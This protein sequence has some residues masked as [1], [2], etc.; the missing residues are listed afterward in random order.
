MLIAACALIAVGT[1]NA[2]ADTCCFPDGTC[3]DNAVQGPCIAAG[4]VFFSGI[5]CALHPCPP[6]GACCEADG[7]CAISA[8][9]GC[10]NRGGVWQGAGSDC[11][12]FPCA[13]EVGACCFPNGSCQDLT[14]DAC[15]AAGGDFNAGVTCALHPCPTAGGACC[16]PDGSCQDLSED[17]CFAAGGDFNAGLS[18]ALHPCP[19]PEGEACP[20]TAGFWT[21]QCKCENGEGGNVKFSCSELDQI[22]ACVD[23]AS[24]FFSW[25]NDRASFCEV[26]DPERPMGQ[27]QQAKRQFAVLLANVCT[28]DLGIIANNGDVVSLP[29]DTQIDACS[30]FD[31]DTIGELIDEID[32]LLGMLEGQPLEGNV[33]TQYGNII[34][35]TDRI[36]NGAGGIPSCHSNDDDLDDDDDDD[37]DDHDD[38]SSSK[39]AAKSTTWG[40]VKGIYR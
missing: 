27:R 8:E 21:Q 33:V 40:N 25:T 16:F 17:A 26:V 31:A 11:V 23:A 32:D 2:N 4:G 7:S 20:R 24:S 39:G 10:L 3:Q 19:P 9:Q 30:G 14:A 36:N 29:A 22:T 1:T 18:C 34:S 38:S 15:F 6:I 5:T 35:C 37:D 13:E 12:P 28:G